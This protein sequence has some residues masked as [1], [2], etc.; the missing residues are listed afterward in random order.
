[1]T[2]GLLFRSVPDLANPSISDSICQSLIDLKLNLPCSDRALEVF[3]Y[4]LSII[5]NQRKKICDAFW[6]VSIVNSPRPK[7]ISSN[8]LFLAHYRQK[9]SHYAANSHECAASSIIDRYHYHLPFFPVG[10]PS[11]SAFSPRMNFLVTQCA[12]ARFTDCS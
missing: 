4:A 9:S 11:S 7:V 1:M 5:K 6:L 3:R 2:E 12:N 10:M 8:W